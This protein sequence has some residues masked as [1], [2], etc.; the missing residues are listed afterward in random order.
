[1]ERVLGLAPDASSARAARG[2]ARTST[3]SEVG[4]TDT[5]VFGRCQGSG[6]EPYQVTVDLT[7]PAFRCTC[8]SRKHPC[9]HGLALLLLWSEHG[10]AVG[11]VT[12]AGAVAGFADEWQRERQARAAGAAGRARAP[13]PAPV[14]PEAQARRQAQREEAMTAGLDELQRWMAD[15]VRGGLAGAHRQPY[16]FWDAMA[17]RLV[18]AQLPAL[19]DR[20]RAVGGAIAGREDWPDVLLAEMGRWQLAAHA[21]TRRAALDR[22]TFADLRVVLGWPWRGD[23]V[24]AFPRVEDRWIVAGVAQGDDARFASQRTWLWGEATRRWVVV[25]DFAAAGAA[26][27]VPQVVGSVV[28]D[29]VTVHPG[30]GPARAAFSGSERVTEAG[31]APPGQGI[32]AALDDVAGWLAADPWRERVPLALADVVLVD[33]GAGWWLVDPTGARLR[34]AAG[35]EPWPLLARSGGAPAAV[36]VEWDAGVVRPLALSTPATHPAPL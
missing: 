23:E 29:A 12:A 31:A 7:E 4:C 24:A 33:D 8:P 18:D 28:I 25:L 6:K 36:V 14:D 10:D 32:D 26:L 19:A 16:A 35:V 13:R 3:W 20:V 9:K 1:V 17:A 34:V 5:L 11:E 15:L 22:A 21:W 27:R 30:T 2:L